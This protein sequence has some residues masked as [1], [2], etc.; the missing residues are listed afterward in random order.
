MFQA[1]AEDAAQAVALQL[2]VQ[3]C[4]KRIDVDRQAAFTPQVV[5]SVFMAGQH[6]VV[7]QSQVSG[8][9]GHE[10]LGV[11]RAVVAGLVLVGKQRGVLPAGLAVGAPVNT[12]SPARQLLA[13][14]PLAL[15]KMQ[16]AALTVF[17]AQFVHQ[18]GGQAPLGWA[19]GVGVP[20]RRV[21][22]LGGDKCRLAAHGQAHVFGHQ[23]RVDLLAQFQHLCPLFFGVRLGDAG[24]LVDARDAHLVR[25][26]DFGLVHQA[27]NRRGG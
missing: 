25:K 26:L 2:V 24:R 7:R 1:L 13:R 8:Q 27:F 11:G 3:A 5:P 15:A 16:K 9:G 4:I 21:A 12:Q 20:F 14:V 19:Q 18:V 23:L 10:P 17:G 6:G 22:V